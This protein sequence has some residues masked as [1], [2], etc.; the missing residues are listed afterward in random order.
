ME[1]RTRVQELQKPSSAR[2]PSQRPGSVW[3]NVASDTQLRTEYEPRKAMT[4]AFRVVSSATKPE[5]SVIVVLW[6][7][8]R[9]RIRTR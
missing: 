5:V 9:I 4:I 8:V 3:T 7:Y 6:L 2:H 1:S